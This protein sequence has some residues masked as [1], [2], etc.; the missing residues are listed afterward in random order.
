MSCFLVCSKKKKSSPVHRSW[1]SLIRSAVGWLSEV[2]AEGKEIPTQGLLCVPRAPEDK[3]I[4]SLGRAPTDWTGVSVLSL[5]HI[6]GRVCTSPGCVPVEQGA[7]TPVG[8]AAQG[9]HCQGPRYDALL[10]HQ[11]RAAP[12]SGWRVTGRTQGAMSPGS[13]CTSCCAAA[14][15]C[16][17]TSDP[18]RQRRATAA[19]FC[20]EGCDP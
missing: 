9:H 16:V 5:D 7:G 6:H 17:G 4:P 14:R 2:T 8:T 15:P 3:D 12:G 18:A 11:P 20:R 1:N 10:S 19:S 13:L